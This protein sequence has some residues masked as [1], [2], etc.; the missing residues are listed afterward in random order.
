[1]T[2]LVGLC[3][4]ILVFLIVRMPRLLFRFIGTSTVRFVVGVLLLLLLNGLGNQFGLYVPINI[5]TVLLSALFGFFG[6]GALLVV[7]VFLPGV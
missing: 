1:M 7:Q 5:F 2:V 6:V 4:F 3:F